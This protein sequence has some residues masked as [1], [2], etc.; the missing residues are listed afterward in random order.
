MVGDDGPALDT[1]L[2][3]PLLSAARRRGVGG[4]GGGTEEKKASSPGCCTKEPRLEKINKQKNCGAYVKRLVS[5][6]S[7]VLS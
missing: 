2:D 5:V 3:G 7:A 6:G 1:V 4:G